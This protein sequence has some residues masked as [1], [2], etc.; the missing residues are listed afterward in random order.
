[1]LSVSAHLESHLTPELRKTGLRALVVRVARM[2]ALGVLPAF[3]TILQCHCEANLRT[4]QRHRIKRMRKAFFY[5][6]PLAA[7]S[8]DTT[9]REHARSAPHL[10]Q[11]ARL[12]NT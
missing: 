6:H 4:I 7:F 5:G 9:S 12:L 1:M 10:Q 8:G 3:D 2:T 11:I